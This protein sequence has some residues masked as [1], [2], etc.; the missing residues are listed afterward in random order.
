MKTYKIN[1]N[2]ADREKLSTIKGIGPEKADEI[3]NYRE[4]QGEFRSVDELQTRLNI[5]DEQ[6]KELKKVL[7]V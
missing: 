1:I 7:E 4:E 3:I 2:E 6:L 5:G